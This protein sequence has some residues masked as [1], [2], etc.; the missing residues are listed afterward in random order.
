MGIADIAKELHLDPWMIEALET[1]NFEALGAPVFA[2]GHLRQY[3]ALLGLATDDLMIAYYRVRGRHDAAPPPIT[4]T[5]TR[6]ETKRRTT[7]AGVTLAGLVLGALAILLWLL[8]QN[9]DTG[10]APRPENQTGT[11][12]P[13]PAEPGPAPVAP[14]AVEPVPVPDVQPDTEAADE[15]NGE[16]GDGSA[17]TDEPAAQRT[18]APPAAALEARDVR[19]QLVFSGESWVEVYDRDGARLVYGM[20]G[21]GTRTVSGA[22]PIEIYLGR[23]RDV[24]LAVN[25]RAYPIPP[26]SIRGNTARFVIEADAG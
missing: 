16:T 4:S 13:A 10:V 21:P 17:P 23:S 7:W 25:G 24:S 8:A 3:G 2:K 9:V 12:Q 6:P 15:A 1:D 5:M 19:L 14:A 11:A 20:Y 22:A 18:G 26:Q